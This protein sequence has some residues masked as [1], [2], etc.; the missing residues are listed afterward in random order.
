M[1]RGG[2]EQR[3]LKVLGRGAGHRLSENDGSCA[4]GGARIC[5]ARSR[6]DTKVD[7]VSPARRIGISVR[8]QSSLTSA[9]ALWVGHERARKLIPQSGL[10]GLFFPRDTCYSYGVR[11]L[12]VQA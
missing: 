11:T 5:V 3:G 4:A 2:R 9:C 1:R 7:Q 10:R 6:G 12:G 8:Q